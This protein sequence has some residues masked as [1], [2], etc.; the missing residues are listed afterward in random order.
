LPSHSSRRSGKIFQKW[1][2]LVCPQSLESNFDPYEKILPPFVLLA[3][4]LGTAAIA[5][6][7]RQVEVAKQGGFV[8][9]IQA[10]SEEGLNA[11]KQFKL[12]EGLSIDLWAAEPLLANPVAIATDEKGR[13]FVAETFRLHAGVSDILAHIEL[14][15]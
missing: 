11:I 5:G 13:W 6:D 3:L 7:E 10:A 9:K 8:P 4:M 1:N 2:L 12:E 15:R 14:A